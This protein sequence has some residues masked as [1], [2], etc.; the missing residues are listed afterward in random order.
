[1]QVYLL[2]IFDLM[3]SEVVAL[4]V[5]HF[6]FE[7]LLRILKNIVSPERIT[8]FGHVVEVEAAATSK[9]T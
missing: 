5:T 9:E 4:Q 6:T 2:I 3:A 1:M 8:T 7:R